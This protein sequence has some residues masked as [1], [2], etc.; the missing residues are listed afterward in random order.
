[1]L[2]TSLRGMAAELGFTPKQSERPMREV[3]RVLSGA[4]QYGLRNPPI[5]WV[6]LAN[7]FIDGVSIYAFYA[8]QP[9]LLELWGDSQAYSIAGLA[10]AIVAGAQILGGYAAPRIRALFA[11]SLGGFKTRFSIMYDSMSLCMGSP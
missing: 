5:R 9:Y 2:A 4:L 7:V 1:M 8:M 6:M 3:K 11:K 10:A